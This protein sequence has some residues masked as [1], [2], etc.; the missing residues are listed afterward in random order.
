MYNNLDAVASYPVH[1]R[2][3]PDVCFDEPEMPV[4]QAVADISAFDS[5]VV[6]IIEIIDADHRPAIGEQPVT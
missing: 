3:V 2:T 4:L 6:E 1:R 5:R